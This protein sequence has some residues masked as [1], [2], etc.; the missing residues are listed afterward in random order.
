MFSGEIFEDKKQYRHLDHRQT[1]DVER[2]VE[3]IY[4]YYWLGYLHNSSDPQLT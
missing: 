2:L 1:T 4:L 3:V